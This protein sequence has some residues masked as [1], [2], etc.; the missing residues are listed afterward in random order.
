M[1]PDPTNNQPARNIPSWGV[2]LK[3][4]LM[5]ASSMNSVIRIQIRASGIAT[6]KQTARASI[7]DFREVSGFS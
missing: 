3:R 7:D 1:N 2:E 6:L 5:F 4:M